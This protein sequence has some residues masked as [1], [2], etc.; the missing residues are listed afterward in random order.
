MTQISFTMHYN[1]I[2]DF[3]QEASLKGQ[4]LFFYVLFIYFWAQ[5]REGERM[6]VKHGCERDT[7]ISSLPHMPQLGTDPATLACTPAGSNWP[8]FS[9]WNNTQPTEPCGFGPDNFSKHN[10]FL[11]KR[12]LKTT[13]IA[14]SSVI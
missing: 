2:P 12:S 8:P 13:G 6:G 10:K 3:T 4:S 11:R 9:L 5:G 7:S 14:H 1:I